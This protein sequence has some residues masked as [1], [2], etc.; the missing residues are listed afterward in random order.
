MLGPVVIQKAAE[1]KRDQLL[2]IDRWATAYKDAQPER[3]LLVGGRA[4]ERDYYIVQF[5]KDDRTTGLMRVNAV[6]GKVG[7]FTGIQEPGRS[8]Y[9]FYRP[10]EIPQLVARDTDLFP[11]NKPV[12]ANDIKVHETLHWVACDQSVTPFMPFYVATVPGVKDDVYVRVD[13]RIA[14]RL[15]H[16]AAGM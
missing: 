16:G 12:A 5:R 7:S 14:T 2:K 9:R 1:D 13:G 11:E 10:E 8:L 3:P 6:T 15:T 4:P